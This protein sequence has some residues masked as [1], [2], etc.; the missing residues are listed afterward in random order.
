VPKELE[1]ATARVLATGRPRASWLKRSLNTKDQREANIRAKLVL[2]E[3]DNIL[4]KAEASLRSAP[5]R[6]DL[7]DQEIDRIADY[8]FASMLDEDDELRRDGPAS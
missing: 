2:I 4:A 8:H 1:E 7:S 3:F 5:L 6:S